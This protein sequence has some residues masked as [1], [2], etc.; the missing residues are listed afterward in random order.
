L[1]HSWLKRLA[2]PRS[3]GLNRPGLPPGPN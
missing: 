2:G 3:R 1:L